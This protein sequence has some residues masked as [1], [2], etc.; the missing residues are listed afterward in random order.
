MNE[1]YQTINGK[2]L[3]LGFTT[4]TAAALAAKAA[5]RMLKNQQIIT[6]IALITPAGME[7][8]TRVFDQ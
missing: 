6:E 1:Y 7:I 4:G 5:A 8:N 3:K 2:K